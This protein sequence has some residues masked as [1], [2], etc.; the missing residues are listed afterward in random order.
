MDMLNNY[1]LS[2][3]DWHIKLKMKL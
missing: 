2:K 3:L 1:M